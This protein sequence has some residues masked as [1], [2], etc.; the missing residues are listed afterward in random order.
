MFLPG[1][2]HG[3]KTLV[4]YS[5]WGHKRVGHHLA[6]IQQQ[7]QSVYIKYIYSNLI[8]NIFCIYHLIY[9]LIYTSIWYMNKYMKYILICIWKFKKRWN[10][11][12]FSTIKGKFFPNT[13]MFPDLKD[14]HKL[15]LCWLCFISSGNCCSMQICRGNWQETDN[16]YWKMFWALNTW[17]ELPYTEGAG[18]LVWRVYQCDAGAAGPVGGGLLPSSM[19]T[20]WREM[21]ACSGVWALIWTVNVMLKHCKS[22][23]T[24]KWRGRLNRS[25]WTSPLT[26]KKTSH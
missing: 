17:M 18:S 14:K 9:T 11:S 3:Q 20:P 8:Y 2:S 4:S 24:V 1:K 23:L 5:P 7:Q 6:T 10:R 22:G 13:D 21:L 25:R 19:Q 12:V 15:F 26:M 16:I